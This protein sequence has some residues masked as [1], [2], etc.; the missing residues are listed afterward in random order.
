MPDGPDKSI[1]GK[2]QK[3]WLQQT[4]L[5]SNAVFKIL[6]SPTPIIGPDRDNKIDNH[7]NTRGFKTEGRA[8]LN[9]AGSNLTNF[10]IVCGDR[11]WQYHSIDES[12]VQE[13][14]AGA[15][16]DVH[17]AVNQP[18]WGKDRQPFFRDAA[19]GFLQVR[20]VGTVDKPELRFIFY[21]VDG[22]PVYVERKMTE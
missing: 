22:V 1:W 21:D 14:S 12:G 9:W 4:L 20:L 8:F 7:V 6:I 2:E 15:V 11:H 19:G 3:A 10:Y 18:H 13:F 16:S 5:A 17:G